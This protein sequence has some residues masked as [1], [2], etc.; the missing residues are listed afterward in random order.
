MGTSVNRL[1]G[2]LKEITGYAGDPVHGPRKAGETFRIYLDATRA[3]EGLGW[4]PTVGL[5]EG[6]LPDGGRFCSL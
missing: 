4:D 5:E 3:R 1:F 6:L 2:L